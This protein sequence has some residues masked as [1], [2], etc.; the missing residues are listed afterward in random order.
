MGPFTEYTIPPDRI[1][2]RCNADMFLYAISL[3][4]LTSLIALSTSP[5]LQNL[6]TRLICGTPPPTPKTLSDDTNLAETQAST[7][8]SLHATATQKDARIST[9]E[10]DLDAQKSCLKRKLLESESEIENAKLMAA[11]A[12]SQQK[13]EMQTLSRD[14]RKFLD[15]HHEYPNDMDIHSIAHLGAMRGRKIERD[16]QRK[17]AALASG[18]LSRELQRTKELLQNEA[19]K[20]KKAIGE[21][22]GRIG[23]LERKVEEQ[24]DRIK[25]LDGHQKELVKTHVDLDKALAR[26]SQALRKEKSLRADLDQVV[27]H[28]DQKLEAAE[29]ESFTLA[30]QL[31]E[32]TA[33][34]VIREKNLN[35][36]IAIRD[37]KLNTACDRYELLEEDTET[38]ERRVD[39]LRSKVYEVGYKYNRL[40]KV[41]N[42]LNSPNRHR[43]S[44]LR[45]ALEIKCQLE[46]EFGPG[47]GPDQISMKTQT[48]T[49]QPQSS[50]NHKEDLEAA[51]AREAK[52]AGRIGELELETSVLKKQLMEPAQPQSPCNHDEDLK[53]AAARDGELTGRVKKLKSVNAGLKKQLMESAKAQSPCNHE[54]DLKAAAAKEVELTGRVKELESE[55]ANSKKQLTDESNALQTIHQQAEAL[56][57]QMAAELHAKD[58]ESVTL[59]E[60]VDQYRRLLEVANQS[61]QAQGLELQK[62]Q[63]EQVISTTRIRDIHSG[64]DAVV[65][66]LKKKQAELE[67]L[68]RGVA[69][70]KTEIARQKGLVTS[71]EAECVKLRKEKKD[72]IAEIERQISMVAEK[73]AER[74]ELKKQLTAKEAPVEKYGGEF[75]VDTKATMVKKEA[76][77]HLA[78]YLSHEKFGLPTIAAVMRDVVRATAIAGEQATAAYDEKSVQALDELVKCNDHLDKLRAL[79]QDPEAQPTSTD[80]RRILDNSYTYFDDT[81][82]K[83]AVPR[84]REQMVNANTRV[85]ELV[86]IVDTRVARATRKALERAPEEDEDDTYVRVADEVIEVSLRKKM[87]DMLMQPRG[88]EHQ[89]ED[90]DMA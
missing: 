15:P 35:D 2:H 58:P 85:T 27:V 49:A 3:L 70:D 86:N 77:L 69:G 38:A 83:Q 8:A 41:L 45:Q 75:E 82:F 87:L 63:K 25:T 17:E 31:R 50:C 64:R 13:K 48:E 22:D 54:E 29:D 47:E 51:A 55:N 53:A 81:E 11:A 19:R 59:D 52:L 90:V 7:I 84:L 12:L 73:E 16:L 80:L 89:L 26:T 18:E 6:L 30:V 44:D 21:R 23:E 28:K 34:F 10:R 40:A 76:E 56:R 42:K 72:D 1:Q 61:T 37:A 78:S 36:A 66:D 24:Q 9:L 20:F 32:A 68:Q 5:Q 14:C 67:K 33:A 57:N 43:W 65:K 60:C 71:K 4:I 79:L 39:S 62:L 74:L 46:L 88:D